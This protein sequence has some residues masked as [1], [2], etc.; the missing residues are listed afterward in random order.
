MLQ[1]TKKVNIL[2]LKNLFGLLFNLA[3]TEKINPKVMR[4]TK[5]ITFYFFAML[6]I[7]NYMRI[8]M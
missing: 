6:N 7:V 8:A 4:K 3:K 5:M 1:Q 2:K